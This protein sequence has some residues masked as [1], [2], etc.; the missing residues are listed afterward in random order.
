MSRQTRLRLRRLRQRAEALGCAF[1]WVKGSD[2]QKR[3]EFFENKCAYCRRK[4]TSLGPR[5]RSIDHF[6][7]LTRGG[8]H[9]LENLV[10]ACVRCNCSKNN[11]MPW[12]W[13]PPRA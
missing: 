4:L 5:Q 9:I 11:K 13:K 7:P 10:P 6:I 1:E 3:I 8:G 2:W 12:E